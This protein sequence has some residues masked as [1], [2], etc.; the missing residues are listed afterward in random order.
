MIL[1]TFPDRIFLLSKRYELELP[2]STA[3]IRISDFFSPS[4][5]I[6]VIT[7]AVSLLVVEPDLL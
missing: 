1:K 6:S 5:Q 2:L 3:K 7:P 4:N